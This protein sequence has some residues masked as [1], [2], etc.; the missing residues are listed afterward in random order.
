MH[1][2]LFCELVQFM[3]GFGVNAFLE[4]VVGK[5][6]VL[7]HKVLDCLLVPFGRLTQLAHF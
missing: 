3:Q 6:Q 7:S 1:G 2:E 4:V 5:V